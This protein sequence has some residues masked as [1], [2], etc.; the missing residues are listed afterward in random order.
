MP[1][2]Y[3]EK[4]N[5]ITAAALKLGVHYIHE[6]LLGVFFFFSFLFFSDVLMDS[7]T[8]TAELGWMI[9]PSVGVSTV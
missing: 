5:L 4:K 6:S 3:R 8:A 1:E 7:M 2:C 9:Y